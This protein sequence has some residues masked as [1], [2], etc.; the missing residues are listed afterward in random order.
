MRASHQMLR[1]MAKPTHPGS[2]ADDL[3]PVVQLLVRGVATEH[4][5]VRPPSVAPGRIGDRAASSWRSSPSTF[6]IAGSAP[7]S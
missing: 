6:Q 5:A 7:W 2:G 3:E 4:D 1:P